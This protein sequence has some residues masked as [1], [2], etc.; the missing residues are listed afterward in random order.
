[1]NE[2]EIFLNN[3]LG[4]LNLI[5]FDNVS[6]FI[7]EKNN[8]KERSLFI[9]ISQSLLDNDFN[10]LYRSVD[11]MYDQFINDNSVT[12]DEYED[13]KLKSYNTLI[14]KKIKNDF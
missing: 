5:E 6:I 1:M 10:E 9:N 3:N 4:F 8:K 7:E 12:I 13:A 11:I 14:E 2:A